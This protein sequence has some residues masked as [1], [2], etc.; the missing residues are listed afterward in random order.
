MFNVKNGNYF[1]NKGDHREI[2]LKR[3][4]SHTWS[5]SSRHRFKVAKIVL[6]KSDPLGARARQC[7]R[8]PMNWRVGRSGTRTSSSTGSVSLGWGGQQV[9]TIN[10]GEDQSW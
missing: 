8:P 4:G 9:K 5:V 1:G 6:E 10:Q 2:R 7:T 3:G